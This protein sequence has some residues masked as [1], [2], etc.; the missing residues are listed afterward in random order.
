[1]MAA[2]ATFALK[3]V[4]GSGAVVSTCSLLIRRP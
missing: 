3:D 4:C 1:L 2:S